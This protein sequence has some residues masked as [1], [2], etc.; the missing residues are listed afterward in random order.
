MKDYYDIL[1]VSKHASLG[2]IKNRY[3]Y[4]VQAYHPDKFE[5]NA[6][7]I[8]AE[9]DFKRIDEAYQVVSALAK[10]HEYDQQQETASRHS[11]KRTPLINQFLRT[12]HSIMPSLEDLGV[13][14][15]VLHTGPEFVSNE[16]AAK[17][18]DNPQAVLKELQEFGKVGSLGVHYSAI[19]SYPCILGFFVSEYQTVDGA[20]RSFQSIKADQSS[21]KTIGLL[22]LPPDL[23]D[24][25]IG[26]EVDL[27]VAD[28][29]LKNTIYK[30]SGHFIIR[31][32]RRQFINS[33]QMVFASIPRKKAL[34]NSIRF[35]RV[36][37]A[38]TAQLLGLSCSPSET[39]AG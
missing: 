13:A 25:Q 28:T 14:P 11:D 31:F 22:D 32:R 39:R 5:S 12:A 6:H 27:E 24:D 38:R 33:V 30:V 1:G 18:S 2:E 34:H 9:E 26:T 36:M 16:D 19:P 3:R 37:D 35:A 7:K 23:G 15:F 29:T 17:R 10:K 8:Q 4:L 21:L 20:T